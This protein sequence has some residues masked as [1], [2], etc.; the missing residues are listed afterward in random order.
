MTTLNS[1]FSEREQPKNSGLHFEP[2]AWL[3][4]SPPQMEEPMLSATEIDRR[5]RAWYARHSAIDPVSC[6]VAWPPMPISLN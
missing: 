3:E 4:D 5:R 1:E 2:L 6:A